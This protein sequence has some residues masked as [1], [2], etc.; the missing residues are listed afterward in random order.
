MPHLT[1]QQRLLR[2]ALAVLAL[3]VVGTAG[4]ALLE[5]IDPFDA[6]YQSIVTIATA[7]V[8]R[9]QVTTIAG[10]LLT[11]AL[12]VVGAGV[13]VYAVGSMA[14]LALEGEIAAYFGGHRMRGR[15]QTLRDHFI[16][17]GFGRVGEAI[18]AELAARSEAFVVIDPAPEQVSLAERRQYLI[19]A[20]DATQ[21]ETL[22]VAGI[23]RARGLIAAS[24]TDANNTYIVLS[25][26]SL[27]PE[28]FIVARSAQAENERKLRQAGADRVVSPYLMAGRQMALAAIQP[29][30][31]ESIQAVPGDMDEQILAQLLLDDDLAPAATIARLLAACP[32]TTVLA[33]RHAGDLIVGP[34]GDRAV[35][36]GDEL[37]VLGPESELAL[38][39]S[40]AVARPRRMPVKPPN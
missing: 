28:I 32:T 16:V 22:V 19:V 26:K 5:G 20:G 1:P 15:I 10:K 4:F 29:L 38:I 35:R 40:G 3:L 17:C 25:A 7:G 30:F 24:N 12:L 34:R 39:H 18:A 36:A 21:D 11:I 23:Q 8:E 33:L 14:Q 2:A 6:L 13:L 37:I 9:P 31:A 27:N